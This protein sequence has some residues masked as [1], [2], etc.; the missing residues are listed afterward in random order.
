[1]AEVA[2]PLRQWRDAEGLSQ[3]ALSD[4][5]G[6]DALTISR[7]ERGDTEPQK[8]HWEKIEEVTGLS[9]AQF[10]GFAEAAE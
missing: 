10:L 4:R 5:L 3:E 9:R 2:H 8:R 1:M 6:V 7:W